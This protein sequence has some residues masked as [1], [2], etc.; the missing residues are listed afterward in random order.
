MLVHRQDIVQGHIRLNVVDG[1]EDVP[2]SSSQYFDASFYLSH[3][4]LD[5]PVRK[6]ALGINRAPEGQSVSVFPLQAFRFHP[7]GSHL[8]RM[9]DIH[10]G[11]NE[12]LD[13]VWK[14]TARME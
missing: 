5:A 13:D 3:H 14:G 4:I 10:P 8:D 6:H 1:S 7:R 11:F 12:I 2:S 9:K